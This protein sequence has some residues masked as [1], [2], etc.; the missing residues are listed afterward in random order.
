MV[1]LVAAVLSAYSYSSYLVPTRGSIDARAASGSVGDVTVSRDTTIIKPLSIPTLALPSRA[2][3]LYKVKDGDTLEGIATALDLPYRQITWSNPGLRNPLKAGQVLRIAPVPGFVITVKSG[4]SLESIA[5]AH[6]IDP[7]SIV[8]FN[9]VRDPLTPGSVLVVP[10]DPAVGPNLPSGVP[11]DPIKPGE[12]ICPLPGAPIIQ[13]FGPTAFSLE[14]PYDGYQHF[15]TGVDILA[16]YGVPIEAAAGG[17]VTAVGPLGAFGI[18]VE[19]TD[20]YGLVEIYAHMEDVSVALGQ[21][22]QQGDKV[23]LVGSTGLSIGSH[24]HLQLEVGGVPTDPGPLV[25]CTA[26]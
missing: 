5:K 15:H 20:S 4:D 22:V 13:K 3:I 16:G 17:R 6:G 26:T 14:P 12:F 9:R 8:D 10:V 23:G 24:L 19:V 18:R 1:L 11:A 25:G 2:P 7:T 21:L